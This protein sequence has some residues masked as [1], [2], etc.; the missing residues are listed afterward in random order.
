MGGVNIGECTVRGVEECD[1][2]KRCVEVFLHFGH[3]LTVVPV[4]HKS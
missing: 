4:G 3:G 1:I 2:S